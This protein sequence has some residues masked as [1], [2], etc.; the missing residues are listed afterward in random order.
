MIRPA[1]CEQ[2][3]DDDFDPIVPLADEVSDSSE[4]SSSDSEV[5]KVWH[6]DELEAYAKR[7]M[8]AGKSK[9]AQVHIIKDED[10][11]TTPQVET[12][13]G[14]RPYRPKADFESVK[15]A[16]AFVVLVK[17]PLCKRCLEKWPVDMIKQVMGL[18]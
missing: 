8:V 10:K 2:P 14:A 16:K 13:C 18:E 9:A 12:L 4:D 17:K 15:N 5:E 1:F 3:D 11:S 7:R 6:N